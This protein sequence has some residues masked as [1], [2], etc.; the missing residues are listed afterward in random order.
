MSSAVEERVVRMEFDNKQF[1]KNIKESIQSLDDLDKQLGLLDDGDAFNTI[2]ENSKKVDFSNCNKLP[3]I[4]DCS[5]YSC[6]QLNEVI[7]PENGDGFDEDFEQFFG[8]TFADSPEIDGR[9][10]IASDEAL[11]EGGFV[12]VCIDG[13]VDGDLSGYLVEE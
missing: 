10:W 13:L 9:V 7:F 3:S 1:E 5:F 4:S 12:K 2:E 11:A 8:R 6:T